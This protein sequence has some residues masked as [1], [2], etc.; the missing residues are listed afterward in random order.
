M[1]SSTPSTG[2][3]TP[4]HS[5]CWT[6]SVR[7]QGCVQPI[8]KSANMVSGRRWS[9]TSWNRALGQSSLTKDSILLHKP[10]DQFGWKFL[11]CWDK[12]SQSLNIMHVI[13]RSDLYMKHR[14]D[15]SQIKN[16]IVANCT[17]YVAGSKWI[18]MLGDLG[19]IVF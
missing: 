4:A 5:H 15:K 10:D 6:A 17:T 8:C 9:I 1:N 3:I 14:N 13:S 7:I 2:P 19:E 18:S 16:Y 12:Q 11:N